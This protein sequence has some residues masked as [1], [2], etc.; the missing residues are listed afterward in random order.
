MASV[1][2]RGEHSYRL[3]VCDGCDSQGKKIRK[4]KVIELDPK[5]KVDKIFALNGEPTPLSDQTIKHYKDSKEREQLSDNFHACYY[6][7]CSGKI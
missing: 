6:N 7:R 3:T 4:R 5:V 2:K 1:E